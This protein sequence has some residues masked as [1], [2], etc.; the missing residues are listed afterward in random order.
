[1]SSLYAAEIA[2]N[3]ERAEQAIQ[4]AASFV[5]A[6]KSLMQAGLP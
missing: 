4:A 1:M 6:I 2:A 3:L 5:A